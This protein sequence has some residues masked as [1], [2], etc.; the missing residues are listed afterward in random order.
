MEKIKRRSFLPLSVLINWLT[1]RTV[2]RRKK[3]IGLVGLGYVIR[4][5]IGLVG[6]G[7]VLRLPVS[8]R[9]MDGFFP[10]INGLTDW[11]NCKQLVSSAANT[12]VDITGSN[13]SYMPSHID[14]SSLLTQHTA[15]ISL[16]C[17]LHAKCFAVLQRTN[18]GNK[19]KYQRVLWLKHLHMRVVKKLEMK[20]WG[21][22]YD[23]STYVHGNTTDFRPA[24]PLS[25]VLMVRPTCL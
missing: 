19:N 16:H 22:N 9:N 24:V 8:V 20:S 21:I 14:C 17:S 15:A 3:S 7:F 4:E 23:G 12:C 25:L 1:D 18:D 6:L 10:L 2:N 5:S 11:L 13:K